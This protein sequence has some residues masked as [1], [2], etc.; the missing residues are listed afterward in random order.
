MMKIAFLHSFRNRF[1]LYIIITIL[2][3]VFLTAGVILYEFEQIATDV[4]ESYAMVYTEAFVKDIESIIGSELI[5][6]KKMVVTKSIIQWL[7]N[8]TDA[9]LKHEALDDLQQFRTLF[10]DNTLFI[11][12]DSSKEFYL[13]DDTTTTFQL[14]PI[15]ILDSAIPEDNWYFET[16]KI[17]NDYQL[18]IDV[19]RFLKSMR[20]WIN[21]K[22]YDDEQNFLGIMGT[23]IN[24]DALINRIFSEHTDN[25]A[26][27]LIINEFGAIQLS[28]NIEDIKQNSFGED[29][30]IKNTIYEWIDSEKTRLSV[31][32]YLTSGTEPTLI[33]IEN[34][35]YQLIALSPIKDTNWYV[36]KLYSHQ[37]LYTIDNLIPFLLLIISITLLFSIGLNL[38]VNQLFVKPFN[39]LN[40]SIQQKE[41][42]HDTTLYGLE[43]NDE[44]GT[45]AQ[46]VKQMTDRMVQSVPVGMF[47][48][49]ETSELV[50]ANPYFLEQFECTSLSD[51]QALVKK[52]ITALFANQNDS[53]L[54]LNQLSQ[55]KNSYR[56]EFELTTQHSHSFWAEIYLTKV[57]AK[58][59]HW[60]YEGIL[61]NVQQKKDYEQSLVNLASTDRLTGL[62]NRLYF[63]LIV[64]EEMLRSDRYNHPVSLILFDLDLFK[65][66]NDTHGHA[67]GDDVLIETAHVAK[68]CLRKTDILA[69]WGGEEFAILMPE[70][71][72]TGAFIV[73]E[74]IRIALEQY[75]HKTAGIVTA[76]FG[77][78]ERYP[79][80]VY[81]DWFERVDHSVFSSK[82]N[83]RNKVS[84]SEKDNSISQGFV[85]LHWQPSF[86]S[87]N[88]MI[89]HEHIHLFSLTNSF[90]ESAL[91]KNNYI[92]QIELLTELLNHLEKHFDHEETILKS[93]QL[94]DE[95]FTTHKRRHTTLTHHCSI[96]LHNL[97]RNELIASDVFFSIL[98]EVVVGHIIN[99][100]SLFFPYTSKTNS[101]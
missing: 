65:L 55:A 31:K 53:T 32:E 48:I 28:S 13:L 17:K 88:T 22:V 4:S 51:L 62:R 30:T 20:V 96:L 69:R 71:D 39:A 91:R 50:F 101:D 29:T 93:L 72:I 59:N 90:M 85:R 3:T 49:S 57:L 11:A 80:E 61:I 24:L 33:A 52:D 70:T 23:G 15:G 79:L 25:G 82:N 1:R 18:N 21:M 16:K 40:Q 94:P 36:A 67:V 35:P 26:Y 99:E 84:V 60:Q 46:S 78:A 97:K 66:V 95:F 10:K 42:L 75:I 37:D 56:F 5:L 45:L 38:I 73:A 81:T 41:Y 19:D 74:K 63:D 89:D 87:G 100:D 9:E 68:Q 92:Q 86:N 12:P 76:S 2:L 83:G 8:T 44:F 98:N 77:V 54:Y 14:E 47:I 27:A 43:R 64:E 58:N 7:K 6:T 34:Q